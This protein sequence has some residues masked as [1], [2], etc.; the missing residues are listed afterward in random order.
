MVSLPRGVRGTSTR[1]SCL[2]QFSRSWWQLPTIPS[3]QS[4]VFL[5]LHPCPYLHPR[6]H[7]LALTSTWNVNATVF[8]SKRATW[9]SSLLAFA[10]TSTVGKRTSEN[11]SWNHNPCPVCSAPSRL[12][13]RTHLCHVDSAR[14][15]LRPCLS[16]GRGLYDFCGNSNG[17][18]VNLRLGERWIVGAPTYREE[19]QAKSGWTWRSAGRL[20]LDLV[21]PACQPQC[22]Y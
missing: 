17:W 11:L 1:R 2:R 12:K 3:F 15:A 22:I 7:P 5:Y 6:L 14:N 21:C 8:F 4:L 19:L 13:T 20:S 10:K 18:G 9:T 16:S